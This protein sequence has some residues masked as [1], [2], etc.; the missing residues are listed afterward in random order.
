MTLRRKILL[1]AFAFTLGI[2]FLPRYLN[3]RSQV[4]TAERYHYIAQAIC[5][6]HAQNGLMP[7]DLQELV[8]EYVKSLPNNASQIY[9]RPILSFEYDL[10]GTYI[11]YSF[12]TEEEGW[13][14]SGT[15]GIG[16]IPISKVIPSVTP[17]VGDAL[18][19]ARLAVY[20]RRIRDPEREMNSRYEK[21]SYLVSLN[22]TDDA[23]RECRAAVEVHPNWLLG[24]YGCI[25][26]APVI[27]SQ[28]AES[29]FR[30]WV[31]GNPAFIHFWYLARYYRDRGRTKDAV[32]AIRQGVKHPLEDVGYSVWVP[33]AYAFEAATF[34]C[35]QK[36]PELVLAITEMWA[37]PRGVYNYP[38]DNLP[39]FRAAAK[40]ALGHFA[41]ARIEADRVIA[42]SR[43]RAI[44]AM[45]LDAL[46]SAIQRKDRSFIYDPGKK[47]DG[48][49]LFRDSE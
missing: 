36:E 41:E 37:D 14:S 17:Q 20:D 30:K 15:F 43:Q 29:R 12:K 23:Y 38:D 21:I 48:P 44:W 2:I 6:F 27:E 18:V 19:Q 45:N 32:D 47:S 31:E 10:F 8:P 49:L 1:F 25:I 28:M 35:Q 46:D 13:Y 16:V 5:D 3:R 40:L 7:I 42:T 33:H 34:A 9:H 22:R 4:Q 39:A 26:F 11:H 24:Q